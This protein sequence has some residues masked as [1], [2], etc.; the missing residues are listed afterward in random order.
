MSRRPDHPLDSVLA[1]WLFALASDASVAAAQ[2]ASVALDEVLLIPRVEATT[3]AEH[4][5]LEFPDPS[6]R[7][8]SNAFAQRRLC[9]LDLEPVSATG[10][11]AVAIQEESST[12]LLQAIEAAG[13]DQSGNSSRVAQWKRHRFVCW[14]PEAGARSRDVRTVRQRDSATAVTGSVKDSSQ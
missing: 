9:R 12:G 3:V 10:R 7:D 14:T 11:P 13:R 5:R 8:K 1:L 2:D 6:L 4:D